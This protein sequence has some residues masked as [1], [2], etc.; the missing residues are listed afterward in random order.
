AE[1]GA[2]CN[3]VDPVF[4]VMPPSVAAGSYSVTG[5]PVFPL[6]TRPRPFERGDVVWVDTGVNL[7][8]YASDFGATWIIGAPPDDRKRDQFARGQAIVDRTL[9]V[10]KPGATAAELARA[11]TG[12]LDAPPWLSYFYLAH[13]VGT[14]SAEMPF[15]GTDLGPAFDE[16]YVLEPG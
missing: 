8:G 13:A 6:P 7:H 2:T 11:A 9:E 10:V 14:D 1:L 4:Q 16:S 5:E 3:T 15:V 12:T